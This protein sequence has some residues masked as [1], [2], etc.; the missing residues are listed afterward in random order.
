LGP[1]AQAA[2]RCPLLRDHL[3]ETLLARQRLATGTPAAACVTGHAEDAE[4]RSTCL[5][6][7]ILCAIRTAFLDAGV[8]EHLDD[9]AMCERVRGGERF[10]SFGLFL[11]VEIVSK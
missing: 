1:G 2:E 9:E 10:F 11:T 5:H 7:P 6:L 3:L 8:L 4:V